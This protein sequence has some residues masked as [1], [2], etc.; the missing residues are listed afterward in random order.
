MKFKSKEE[1]FVKLASSVEKDIEI[2]QRF[3]FLKE[4]HASSFG[5]IVEHIMG[6]DEWAIL[7]PEISSIDQIN[8][9]GNNNISDK[10]MLDKINEIRALDESSDKYENIKK[11]LMKELNNIRM[12]ILKSKL[13]GT[14][15]IVGAGSWDRVPEKNVFIPNISF[16]EIQ[17]LAEDFNQEAF[18]FGSGDNFKIYLTE[19]NGSNFFDEGDI[20]KKFKFIKQE[21]KVT[22]LFKRVKRLLDKS[23]APKEL[24]KNLGE[25][26][27][28]EEE[29]EKNIRSIL[30]WLV[31]KKK[32]NPIKFK[33][34]PFYRAIIKETE[35]IQKYKKTDLSKFN[36]KMFVFLNED[37]KTEQEEKKIE[38]QREKIREYSRSKKP[39]ENKK[40]SSILYIGDI[41]YELDPNVKIP[42][43]KRSG[44]KT[45]YS[46]D[47]KYLKTA[48]GTSM[49]V[50]HLNILLYI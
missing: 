21:D 14:G 7:S 39:V 10:K 33:K 35:K 41:Y 42:F 47:S 29:Q 30:G 11:S 12:R 28:T 43:A 37:E 36:N 27:L 1:A 31:E 25:S 44:E 6:V 22:E 19:S 4:V 26:R 38:E 24:Y 15:F 48:R 20:A 16:D 18:V 50:E 2:G 46:N 9:I 40:V 5:R 23:N 3:S 45:I 17:K 13:A 34:H 32:N 8:Q 49:S